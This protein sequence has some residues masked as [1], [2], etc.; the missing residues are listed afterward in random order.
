[1]KVQFHFP[2]PETRINYDGN[3][4]CFKSLLQRKPRT[5]SPQERLSSHPFSRNLAKR[6]LGLTKVAFDRTHPFESREHGIPQSFVDQGIITVMGVVS[7]MDVRLEE[8]RVAQAP[9]RNLSGG[10]AVGH[11]GTLN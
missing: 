2:I 8:S 5:I 4:F 3:L 1:M 11:V 6:A 10:Q 7:Y 9:A